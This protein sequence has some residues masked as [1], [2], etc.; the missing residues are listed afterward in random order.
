MPPAPRAPTTSYC[1]TRVPAARPM[2]GGDYRASMTACVP[3]RRHLSSSA[4]PVR[5]LTIV[6]WLTC[7]HAAAAQAPG[8]QPLAHPTAADLAR[9]AKVFRTYCSRCHGVEGTGG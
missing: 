4:M 7:M 1:P 9:G 8:T 3:A 5:I 2:G 6:A